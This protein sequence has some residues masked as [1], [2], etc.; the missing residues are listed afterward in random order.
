MTRYV[1]L[2][3]AALAAAGCAAGGSSPSLD[4]LLR[5][6]GLPSSPALTEARIAQGLKEALRVGTERAVGLTGRADGYFGNARIRIPMPDDLETL[7]RTLRR[8]GLGAQV[9]RF[10]V[11]MNR[12][13]EQAAPRAKRIF[14]DAVTQMTIADAR[15]IL[16]GPDAAAT[17]YFRGKTTAPLTAAFRPIVDRALGQVGV[18]RQYQALVAQY[19]RIPLA[20]PQAVD[21]D[22]YVT[23]RAL[24]GLFLVLG[25]EERKIRTDPAARTTEILRDVFGRRS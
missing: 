4:D 25:E 3:L 21:L 9:D 12:A 19:N 20:R 14:W 22:D 1:A 23:A 8:V 6:A 17:D 18:T 13:A 11:S 2:L 7:E 10:V 24:A 16:D 5:G 15:R